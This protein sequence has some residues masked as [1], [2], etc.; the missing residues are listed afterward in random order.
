MLLSVTSLCDSVLADHRGL[1]A[2]AACS[3]TQPRTVDV[4]PS[5]AQRRRSTPEFATQTPAGSWHAALYP[6]PPGT[7]ARTVVWREGQVKPEP[8][9]ANESSVNFDRSFCHRRAEEIAAAAGVAVGN[10]SKAKAV[11]AFAALEVLEATKQGEISLHKAWLWSKLP[12]REQQVA[13]RRY[14]SERAIRATWRKLLN[15]QLSVRPRSRQHHQMCA[16]TLAK[17]TNDRMRSARDS[18]MRRQS[19]RAGVCVLIFHLVQYAADR[20]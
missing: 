5:G 11:F 6:Y 19:L 16:R 3:L 7:R 10:I 8:R 20:L 4:P 17:G 9:R 14:P 13:Y 1:R 12:H 2:C 15:D 18:A